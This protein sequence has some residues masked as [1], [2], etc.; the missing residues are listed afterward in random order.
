MLFARWNQGGEVVFA[1]QHISRRFDPVVQ[2]GGLKLSDDGT[3]NL[4]MD[5][6][7]MIRI[8]G[9]T[10]PFVGNAYPA[11][12]SENPINHEDLAM[13]AVVKLAQSKPVH[14]MVAND[15]DARLGHGID[16]AGRYF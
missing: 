4:K 16:Q 2:K 10:E 11:G 13:G 1:V 12:K 15:F 3:G 9:V 5:V 8:L 6:P 14:R 7:P